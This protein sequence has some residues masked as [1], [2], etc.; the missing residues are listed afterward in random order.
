M[1]NI[2][3]VFNNEEFGSVRTLVDKNGEV[4]FVG[5]D[6]AIILGYKDLRRMYDHADDDEKIKVNPNSSSSLSKAGF[7]VDNIYDNLE[8]NP[9]VKSMILIN[10]SGLYSCIFGSTLASAKKFKKWVTSEVLPSIRKTGSYNINNS[11]QY[12]HSYLI[13][14]PIERALAWI[15][16]EKIRQAQK[17]LL[18]EQAPKVEYY[19]NVLNAQNG[20][21]TT[22]IAKSIGMSATKLNRILNELKVQFKRRDQWLL[23][24]KYQDKGYTL[25]RTFY[26]EGNDKTRHFTV[27]TEKGKEFI[28]HTLKTNNII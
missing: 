4:W 20:I 12:N 1:S 10:E 19:N 13:E 21:T 8:D 11:I 16:E 25:D 18:L 7:D 26:D 14:D 9:N 6:V 3:Q 24:E 27:W 28:I 5:R 2:V 22:Q 23:Y 15:E 17:Q